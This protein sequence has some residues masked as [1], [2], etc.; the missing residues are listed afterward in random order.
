MNKRVVVIGAGLGG[1]QCAYIL[2]KQ[3]MD[4]TVLEQNAVIGGCL[5]SF[6][7]GDTLFDTGFHYVG[8]LR[9][10]ESL[11]PLFRYFNL[12]DLPWLQLDEACVDE[13]VLGDRSYALAS[14]HERFAETLTESF[15]HEKEGIRRYTDFLRNVGE[16]IF[17]AFQPREAEDFYSTSLF[18][19]SAYDFL[20]E[21]IHDPVLRDVL[22][23]SSLKLEL[24]RDTLPLYIFAQINNS[25]IQSA[26]RLRGGGQQIANHLAAD[27]TRMGGLVRTRAGV[28]RIED[29]DG[30]AAGVWVNGKERLEADYIICDIHPKEVMRLLADSPTVRKIYRRRIDSLEETFGMFTANI[31]L[32]AGALPYLNRNIYLHREGTDLWANDPM[33]ND[34]MINSLMVSFYPDQPALDLL[35]PVRWSQV[36]DLQGEAYEAFKAQKAEE[37]IRLAEQRL[38]ALRG[39]IDKVY[40]SSPLTY[41]RY[42][43]TAEGSAYG[44]RKNWQSPLTTVLAPKTP[45]ENVLLTGQNLNLHG[46]LGVSMTSVI[47]AMQIVGKFEGLR[48]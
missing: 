17:D 29:K 32:K 13:V 36:A 39:A 21:T 48:V 18:A 35:T 4:V 34:K 26:W 2:A 41:R 22:S 11:Y 19:R 27:I 16:H 15:P 33:M 24:N 23:G 6:R 14:G 47:T 40:T 25:F 28:T 31:R 8:G 10:G 37:C 12:L 5:Q 9:E 30:R 45:V 46:V 20:C 43:H 44:I 38:P 3:G 7:R 42:T 1:L